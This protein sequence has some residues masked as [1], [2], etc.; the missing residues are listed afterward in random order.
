MSKFNVI[1]KGT[2][3]Y[4]EGRSEVIRKLL[5]HYM[6]GT[7]AGT[8]AHFNKVASQVSAHE[9]I[10]DYNRHIYVKDE[11][12]AWH[13]RQA[14][15]F[16]KGYETSADPNRPPSQKSYENLVDSLSTDIKKY[17]LNPDNDIEGH[18][19]YVATSCPGTVDM[20]HVI[21]SVKEYLSGHKIPEARPIVVVPKAP[22]VIGKGQLH[23]PGAATSWRVYPIGAAPVVGHEIGYLN[24]SLF[25]GLVYDIVGN[26]Q[27]DVYTINTRDYG[28]VNIFAGANT[29]A[30]VIGTNNVAEDNNKPADIYPTVHLPAAANTW[31]I[32][33]LNK[34]PVVGN[35]MGYLLPGKFGGLTYEVV[36]RLQA[37]VVTIKTR[38]FGE[39]NIYVGSDTGAV[40]K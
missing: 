17:G 20:G 13:A 33:P 21:F 2:S 32:Y 7:L 15:P 10:E 29:G 27:K 30:A 38:D 34:A 6:N 23:L 31:R 5:V 4:W 12:T 9:G 16:S 22:K 19:V 37:D 1:W 3:N 14:N 11:N 26:P 40:L 36:G 35:E 28:T 25:G 18:N 24:P 39:G 8:D